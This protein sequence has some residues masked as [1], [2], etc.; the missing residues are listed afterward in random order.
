MNGRLDG[1]RICV[2]G[3]HYAPE[4]TGNAPYTTALAEALR[5]GGA[6]VE[7]V[8]GI[9]HY[10]QWR[11]ID[12]KYLRGSRWSES[13]NGISITRVKH[14]VPARQGLRG[15]AS[16]EVGF[17]FRAWRE[18]RRIG[19]D[20][21]VA[22]TPMLSALLA[23]LAARRGRPLG[24]LVQDLTG[25]AARESGAATRSVGSGIAKV[26][27]AMFRRADRVGVIARRFEDVLVQAGISPECVDVLANF[28]HIEPER[29]SRVEA[30]QRLGWNP[31]G[32]MAVHTGNMGLKQGLEV[33]VEAALVSERTGAGVEFVL[34]GDGN[35]RRHLERLA[36]GCRAIRFVD[37]LDNVRYPLALAAADVLLLTERPGVREMSL[38]S[39]LTSYT[40][41]RRPI[42][43]AV[44]PGGTTHELLAGYG[45]ARFVRPGD[46]HA[47]LDAVKE[48]VRHQP[49]WEH[50][51]SRAA[52]MGET[53]Y[54]RAAAEQRYVRFAE[55]LA[56]RAR[57]LRGSV[58]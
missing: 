18:C 17:A 10:P 1:V 30:R 20:V 4:T 53:E 25:N 46:Q 9:P 32:L 14:A 6:H 7:V 33:A 57:P 8:T 29:V 48:V 55:Q 28:T 37:P 39:K 42:V 11:I 5:H 41:A 19:F 43:A 16:M 26:E 51:A 22:V 34:V 40:V 24:A 54:G 2:V 44:E 15:R 56:A 35:Q 3:M 45:A 47:L 23:A 12:D 31:S 21:I 38:P 58:T 50:L 13:L 49:A 27:Y 36:N 52:A